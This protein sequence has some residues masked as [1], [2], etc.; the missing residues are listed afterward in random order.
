[1]FFKQFTLVVRNLE[2]SI[3]FYETFTELSITR[4]FKDG[5]AELVFLAN[6][7]GE[8]ELELVHSESMQPFEGKG[9]FYFLLD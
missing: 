2:E 5:P 4:R 9:F 3:E 1:M 7:I 6:K 8:T